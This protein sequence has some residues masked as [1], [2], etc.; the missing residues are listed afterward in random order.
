MFCFCFYL[1][2]FIDSWQTSDLKIYWT[3]LCQIFRVARTMAVDGQSEI[4]FSI[5]EGTLS[6]QP[7]FVSFIHRTDF[8]HAS[9]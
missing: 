2:I 9:G 8:C 7:I 6:W 5:L 3:D 1:F 4:R